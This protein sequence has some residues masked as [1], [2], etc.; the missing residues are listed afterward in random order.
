MGG[1]LVSMALYSVCTFPSLS[2]TLFVIL[3]I[4]SPQDRQALLQSL[5]SLLLHA[6]CT[7]DV[8][9]AFPGLIL[10]LLHRAKDLVEDRNGKVDWVQHQRLCIALSKIVHISSDARWWVN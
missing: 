8:A 1:F 2:L 5:A 6:N 3:Q 7:V 4:W 10:D 9:A